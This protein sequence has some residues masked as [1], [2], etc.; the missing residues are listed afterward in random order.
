YLQQEAVRPALDDFDA[1]LKHNPKDADA[2]IGRGTAL[3][4]RGRAED[5]APATAAAEKALRAEPR[6]FARLMDCVR[7]YSRAAELQKSRNPRLVNDPRT[8]RYAQLA[9][10]LLR[11]AEESLP[12]KEQET[13]WQKHVRSDPG[14][15]Q[16]VRTY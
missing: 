5:V 12:E 1:A 9:L 6:T 16:L 8:T 2:L 10:R 11:E 3:L 14:L 15:L 13:F 4:L 7:I